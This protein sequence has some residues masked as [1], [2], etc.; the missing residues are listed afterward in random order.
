MEINMDIVNRL[1]T[2]RNVGFASWAGLDIDPLT[3]V[4]PWTVTTSGVGG[5]VAPTTLSNGL[6]GLQLTVNPGVGQLY[7]TR[8]DVNLPYDPSVNIGLWIEID[9]PGRAAGVTIAL[10]NQASGTYTD[11]SL[12]AFGAS[13]G[14]VFGKTPYF[15]ALNAADLTTG[16]GSPATNGAY[17]SVRI[18]ILSTYANQGCTIKVSKLCYAPT[19]RSKIC[20][21]FDDGY[22]SQYRDAFRYLARL[23]IPGTLAVTSSLING[24]NYCT[25]NQLKDM[26][27]AGWSMVCHAREHTGFNSAATASICAAQTPTA[28]GALSLNGTI[29]TA[30]FDSPRHVVLRAAANQGLK[31]TIVGLDEN[32]AAYTEDVYSWTN[33]YWVPTQRLMSKV[34]SITIDAAPAGAITVGTSLSKEE[35]IVQM[36][37]PRDFL[38]TNGM[39]RGANHWVYPSGEFN[40]TSTALL[41]KLGFKSARIVGGIMQAPQVGDFRPYQ[42][43]GIGGGGASLTGAVLNGYRTSAIKTGSNQIIYL[44]EIISSGTPGTTQTLMSDLKTFI[45]GCATDAAAGQCEF[46]TQD[47]L[48]LSY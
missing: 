19:A 25:L 39:T 12:G 1:G 32:N 33:N 47:Q 6:P 8:G 23:G 28:A 20:L 44:H 7:I 46:V 40:N 15:I 2:G 16:G 14:N 37:T 43:S 5:S 34:N 26:Y 18:R 17:L 30:I 41:Q 48:P 29:G 36:V 21:T 31:A 22:L 3:S 42:L 24:V 38:T 35:M 9:D 4:T 45:D 27:A 11:W 10:S 13:G